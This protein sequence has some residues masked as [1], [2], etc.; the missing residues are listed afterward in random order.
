[1]QLSHVKRESMCGLRRKVKGVSGV[2]FLIIAMVTP[3]QTIP[4][5]IRFDKSAIIS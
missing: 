3:F 5:P 4:A 2:S 1:M